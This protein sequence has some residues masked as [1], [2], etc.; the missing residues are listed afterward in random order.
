M[1]RPC[2]FIAVALI[3][4]TVLGNCVELPLPLLLG[5]VVVSAVALLLLRRKVKLRVGLLFAAFAFAGWAH[6]ILRVPAEEAN[7]VAAFVA[8]GPQKVTLTGR[9]Q[10][11]VVTIPVGNEDNIYRFDVE[12]SAFSRETETALVSGKVRVYINRHEAAPEIEPGNVISTQ[13][14]LYPLNRVTNPGQTDYSS[15]YQRHDISARA[16][17][18]KNDTIKVTKRTK[19]S[20]PSRAL[21]AARQRILTGLETAFR[22]KDSKR[23]N[24]LG[25]LLVGRWTEI[26]K[27][28]GEI[29][30]KT[31]TAHFLALSGLHVAIFAFFLWYILALLPIPRKVR[32]CLVMAGLV[33]DC[34]PHQTARRFQPRLPALLCSRAFYR[35]LCASPG[36]APHCTR[37]L[38][39]APAAAG[40]TNR[41]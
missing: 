34:H 7:S 38:A 14:K 27:H 3:T 33:C 22:G 19:A 37:A 39:P 10:T 8:A 4:G 25:G 2:A 13:A 9:V 1:R 11:P 29:K 15:Y 26:D 17:V 16:Y 31:G 18:G 12:V 41:P 6:C 36:T 24:L 5:F 23:G 21:F 32:I 35:R 30:H 28:T 20:W 40:G